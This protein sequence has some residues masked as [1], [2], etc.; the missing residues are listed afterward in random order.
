MEFTSKVSDFVGL[1]L[2]TGQTETG[3]RLS[4]KIKE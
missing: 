4:M 2:T 3:I 1:R